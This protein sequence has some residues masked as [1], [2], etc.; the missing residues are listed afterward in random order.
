MLKAALGN[1]QDQSN[2]QI[3]LGERVRHRS[4]RFSS[5]S[6]GGFF[7]LLQYLILFFVLIIGV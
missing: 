4:L 2:N 5:W 6:P 1:Q 3:T 7:F